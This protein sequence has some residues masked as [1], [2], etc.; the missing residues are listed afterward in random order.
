MNQDIKKL[1]SVVEKFS[2]CLFWIRWFYPKAKAIPLAYLLYFF[3]PQKIF[4]INGR[5]PWP[6]HF[7]SRVLYWKNIKVGNRCTPG[8]NAC[9]YIQARNG[10]AIGHNFRMGPGVGLI[11]SN[12]DLND[13]D[14]HT[15]EKPIVIGNNVWIGMNSVVMPGITIGDNAVIGA[16]SVV[17]QDIPSNVI[18]A[19]NPCCV[20]RVKEPY[21]GRDYSGISSP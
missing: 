2:F 15:K 7:T 4:R 5:V 3:I 11:S 8:M 12:H 17:T 18:A 1:V 13:Y 19:G 20:I 6:M 10:I 16:N 14:A 9:C 21:K